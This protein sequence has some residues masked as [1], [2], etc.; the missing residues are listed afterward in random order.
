MIHEQERSGCKVSRSTGGGM[1][2]PPVR[3][4]LGGGGDAPLEH[5]IQ[6]WDEVRQGLRL[7]GGGAEGLH[8]QGAN[9]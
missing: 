7:P 3:C 5:C 8:R 9:R 6:P 2:E 1:G 4:G